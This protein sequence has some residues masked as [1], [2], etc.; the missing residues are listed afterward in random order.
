[1][2]R[3]WQPR[4]WRRRWKCRSRR[5]ELILLAF[6]ADGFVWFFV[7]FGV[8]ARRFLLDAGL[9]GLSKKGMPTQEKCTPGFRGIRDDREASRCR[10]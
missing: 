8:A 10:G 9:V 6:A 5:I 7:C 4:R 1:V 2:G 3:A